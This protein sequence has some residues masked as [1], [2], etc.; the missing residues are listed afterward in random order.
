MPNRLAGGS[1]QNGGKPTYYI[2]RP[3]TRCKTWTYHRIFPILSLRCYNPL[4]ALKCWMLLQTELASS[5]HRYYNGG[6]V[7]VPNK[8]QLRQLMFCGAGDML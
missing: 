6:V 3:T 7:F 1:G 5:K 4:K 8:V 2:F